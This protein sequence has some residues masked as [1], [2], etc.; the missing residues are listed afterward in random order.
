MKYSLAIVALLGLTSAIRI[1]EEPAAA[2]AA[3]A[4]DKKAPSADEVAAKEAGKPPAAPADPANPGKAVV[5]EALKTE[6][7]KSDEAAAAAG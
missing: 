4:E 5:D 6:E 3:P 2:P 1:Y 7:A